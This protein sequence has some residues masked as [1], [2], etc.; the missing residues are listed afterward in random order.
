MNISM[1]LGTVFYSQAFGYFL[2]PNPFVVSASAG[3]F[4]ASGLVSVTFIYLL[5]AGNPEINNKLS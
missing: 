5:F 3:F 4:V 1:M 2:Q